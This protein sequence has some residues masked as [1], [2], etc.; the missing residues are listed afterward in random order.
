MELLRSISTMSA[1]SAGRRRSRLTVSTVPEKPAPTIIRVFRIPWKFYQGPKTRRPC[2]E[3]ILPLTFD[4]VRGQIAHSKRAR[5]NDA[6]QQ[7][8]LLLRFR[9]LS[10]RGERADGG[11]FQP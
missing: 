8:Q 7:I 3:C 9:G 1:P 10:H 5:G 11:Q 2:E 6:T 4:P